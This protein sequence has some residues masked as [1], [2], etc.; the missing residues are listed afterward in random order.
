MMMSTDDVL[1]LG[2]LRDPCSAVACTNLLADKARSYSGRGLSEEDTRA[3]F[4]EPLLRGLGWDTLDNDHLGRES[5]RAHL[6]AME[7]EV[8]PIGLC[9]S[10][11]TFLAKRVPLGQPVLLLG[12]VP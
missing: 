4:V 8:G 11:S 6:H 7:G 10:G 2:W 9:Q 5:R 3:I 12:P 1:S